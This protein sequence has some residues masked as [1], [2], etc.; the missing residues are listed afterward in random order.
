MSLLLTI[1]LNVIA[2]LMIGVMN[3]S[4]NRNIFNRYC[5]RPG[6]IRALWITGLDFLGKWDGKIDLGE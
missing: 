4:A 1:S 5:R 3:A 6:L 2:S